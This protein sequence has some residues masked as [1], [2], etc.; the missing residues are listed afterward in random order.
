MTALLEQT[1]RRVVS[2][3]VDGTY[4]RKSV[5]EAAQRKGNG[6]AVRVLIPSARG[7]RLR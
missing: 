7:A 5:Y 6:Q 1:D 2:L 3:S 4:D